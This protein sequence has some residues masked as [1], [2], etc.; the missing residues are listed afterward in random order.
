MKDGW[1]A[2]GDMATVRRG[3]LLLHRRP[4]EGHDHPR[5]LQRL[6]ARDRGG[7]LRAPGRLRGRGHRRPDDSLGEEVAAMVVL[8]EGQDASARTTSAPT[9][10]SGSRPTSTRA[11]S[12]SPRTPQRPDGQDPQARD[13]APGVTPGTPCFGQRASGSAPPGRMGRPA[14]CILVTPAVIVSPMRV[15]PRAEG[16]RGGSL[17]DPAGADSRRSPPH[18]PAVRPGTTTPSRI[19]QPPPVRLGGDE[20]AARCP[21]AY[22]PA[23]RRR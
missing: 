5:R 18:Q 16:A 17:V 14:D 6:P 3:R 15:A 2:T 19:P 11:R 4:Q 8:K 1:F 20:P 13:Q 23:S 7:P 21:S 22:G 10:R 12:G 9:P